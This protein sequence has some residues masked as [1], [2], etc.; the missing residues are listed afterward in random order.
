VTGKKCIKVFYEKNGLG[1]VMKAKELQGTII[2]SSLHT[3]AMFS[4]ANACHTSLF[5]FVF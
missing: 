5:L 4:V 2:T 3:I 1:V